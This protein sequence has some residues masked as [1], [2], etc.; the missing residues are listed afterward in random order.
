MIIDK[1][2]FIL[3]GFKGSNLYSEAA[4]ETIATRIYKELLDDLESKD[5]R[6]L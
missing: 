6:G 4:R 2:K 1:I 3:E 5:E